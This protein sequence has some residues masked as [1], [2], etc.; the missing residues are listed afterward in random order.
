MI[1]LN[2]QMRMMKECE[3]ER[4]GEDL[5]ELLRG[6]LLFACVCLQREIR[7][8]GVCL[9]LLRGNTPSSLDSKFLESA[10]RWRFTGT[11][12]VAP[13]HARIPLL[14]SHMNYTRLFPSPVFK[15]PGS[16]SIRI[17]NYDTGEATSKHASPP[18]SVLPL[19]WL[20]SLCRSEL[21][22]TPPP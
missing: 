9:A 16:R 7:G 6:L 4:D 18:S 5:K 17:K 10:E 19:H 11:A 15:A 2:P 20:V 3:A 14:P 1:F 13:L 8:Q 22:P 12:D 21:H